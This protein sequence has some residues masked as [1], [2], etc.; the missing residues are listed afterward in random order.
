MGSRS[1]KLKEVSLRYLLDA[2]VLIDAHRDYYPMQ[3]VPEFW[4]W[5]I[6]Q[7]HE[8][9]VKIPVEVYEELARGKDDLSRWT[10][11]PAT[12]DALLL[13][14]EADPEHVSHVVERGY[15]SNLTDEEIAKLGRDPFLIAYALDSG[16][17]CV[18]TTENSKPRAQRANRKIP[19]VCDQLGIPWCGPFAFLHSLDFKTEWKPGD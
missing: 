12:K 11:D 8:D 7:G 14:A 10:S 15:A 1:K 16:K 13:D 4:D 18:V 5:L 17:E 9:R 3:R 19:D 6:H 2:N